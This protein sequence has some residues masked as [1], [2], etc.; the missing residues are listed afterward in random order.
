MEQTELVHVRN[1]NGPELVYHS[2]S[3]VRVLERDGLRFKD[4]AKDGEL[5][6]YEDWRL[7]PEQRAADLASRLGTEELAGLMIFSEYQALPANLVPISRDTYHGKPYD[8]SRDKPWD[9]TDGQEA[10]L[11]REHC[12]HLLIAKVLSPETVALWNNE[13]QKRAEA[14]P[15]GIPVTIG[16]DPRHSID[17]SAEFNMGNGS[18]VD[19][20][21]EMIGLGATFDPALVKEHAEIVAREYRALGISTALH[22]QIDLCTEPRWMRLKGTFG[23]SPR[24]SADMARAYCDGLQ[25]SEGEK[26]LADGWGYESVNAMVKHWPGGATGE[27]GRD[28]HF[29][30]GKYAVYPGHAFEE[31]LKPF[32]EGAFKLDGPTKCASSVMPYY[33][34]S[35]GQDAAEGNNVA[36]AY[37]KYMI[38][39]LLRTKY[40][41]EGVVCTDWLVAED[42]QTSLRGFGGRCWGME[43][44]NKAQKVFRCVEAGVDQL[45]GANTID[46]LLGAYR[47]SCEAQGEALT[48]S[49]YEQSARRILTALF[50]L[51]LFENPYV[52]LEEARKV[53]ASREHVEKGLEAQRRS[54]VLLKNRGSV[55]PL[56]KKTKVYVPKKYYRG[57][58]DWFGIVTPDRGYDWPVEIGKVKEYFD[59]TEDPAEAEVALVFIES[60]ESGRGYDASDVDAGGNGYLPISLQYRPYTAETAREHSIAGGD[61]LEASAERSYRGKTV[62]AENEEDLDRVLEARR[63]MGDR[64]VIVSI[65]LSR[66][67]VMKEFEPAADAILADFGVQETAV[68]DLLCGDAEPSA[69][70]PLQLPADMETVEA[71]CEDLPFDLRC[72]TD[73][74]GHVYD[75][76]YGMNWRGVIQDERVKNYQYK[77]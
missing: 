29:H 75:F 6:P 49:R 38:R 53:F 48:R 19:V 37:S 50:R 57:S 23:E 16:S 43:N 28:A 71:H 69:L 25:T 77:K 70:L 35:F 8:E 41:F 18:T 66:G 10:L 62:R 12:R 17:H 22:P 52:D 31:H 36:N 26:E 34:I 32:T 68:L 30:Y 54:V 1:E 3:G 9:L 33:T 40:G 4:L 44:T 76:A 24:M 67:C 15:F 56:R 13:L 74:E 59:V 55:L 21:P 14:E 39:D 42:A 64:P 60:P 73:T 2:G 51:G 65:R 20:W 46:G 61:P 5:H 63:V 7:S 72:H 27:G 47:L 45:G 11:C 58:V